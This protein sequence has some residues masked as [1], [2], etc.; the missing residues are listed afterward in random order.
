MCVSRRFLHNMTII[1]RSL[2]LQ[3]LKRTKGCRNIPVY[4]SKNITK[5]LQEKTCVEIS[6]LMPTTLLK[7]TAVYLLP[8]EFCKIFQNIYFAE[9]LLGNSSAVK[10]RGNEKCAKRPENSFGA[11]FIR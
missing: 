2:V 6:F 1:W 9:H 11:T 3:K 10:K 4:V 5:R 7:E 8:Y